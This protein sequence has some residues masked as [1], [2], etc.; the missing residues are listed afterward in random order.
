M[1]DRDPGVDRYARDPH[2]PSDWPDETEASVFGRPSQHVR[3]LRSH[4]P[5]PPAPAYSAPTSARPAPSGDPRTPPYSW[6]PDPWPPASPVSPVYPPTQ[7]M[8]Q[9]STLVGR[10][11][12]ASEAYSA[13]SAYAPEPGYPTRSTPA[14]DARR[15]LQEQLARAEESQRA[16]DA[17]R[18]FPLG[19]GAL[20]GVAG[21]TCLLLALMVLPWFEVEGEDVTRSDLQ[22]ALA[23]PE[24]DADDVVPDASDAVPTSLPSGV[25]SPGEV[26]EVG[27]AVEQQARDAVSEAATAAIDEGRRRYLELYTD[28]LWM[29]VAGA[30][31]GAV[32]FST[33][34]TPRSRL[35]SLML[36]M[37]VIAGIAVVA[38]AAAHGVAL[39]VVFGGDGAPEP[40]TGVWLGIG[41][42]GA[43]LLA[44]IVGPKR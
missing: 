36:G 14:E 29:A 11:P 23:I 15:A 30:A 40:A 18:G 16:R 7:T 22:A 35:L 41:G 26:G 19:L 2:F 38:A 4:P 34:L 43:V 24:A 5:Q 44:A 1:S 39:W 37:R 13:R 21:V 32:L 31:A 27:D 33:I 28:T 10:S 25:P 8:P 17:R 6:P 42:L 12:Y 3:G 9:Q 20:L